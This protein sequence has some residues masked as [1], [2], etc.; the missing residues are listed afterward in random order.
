[1]VILAS[2]LVVA[3]LAFG[4][5]VLA[6]HAI[7]LFIALVAAQLLFFAISETPPAGGSGDLEASAVGAVPLVA[8]ASQTSSTIFAAV[9]GVPILLP[10]MFTLGLALTFLG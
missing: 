3:V 10:C 2:V 8:R 5:V 9:H 6:I 1:M 7:L 4:L